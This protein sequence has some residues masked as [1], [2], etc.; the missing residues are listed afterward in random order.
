MG[1]ILADLVAAV[2]DPGLQERAFLAVGAKSSVFQLL[3]DCFN[4]G[5]MV[6]IVDSSNQDVVEDTVRVWTLAAADPL[7]AARRLVLRRF[8]KLG[9]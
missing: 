1:T 4:V 9:D 5:E 3:Q 8:R 2:V 7:S 6:I